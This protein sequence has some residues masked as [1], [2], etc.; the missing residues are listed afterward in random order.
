MFNETVW[1]LFWFLLN[2]WTLNNIYLNDIVK[3]LILYQFASLVFSVS[4][5]YLVIR[6]RGHGDGYISTL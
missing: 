4:I 3:N 1:N 2:L 5:I 6:V